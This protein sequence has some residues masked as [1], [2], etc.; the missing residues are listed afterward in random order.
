M[1]YHTVIISGGFLDEEFTL[2]MLQQN[3]VQRI[4]GVDRGIEFL[5]RN[6]IKP[7]LLLGDM[8]SVSPTIIQEYKEHHETP[9]LTY[10][11]VKDASDTE[12]AVRY[13]VEH[14]WS[15][16]VILGA[17]GKRHDHLLANIQILMIALEAGVDACILDPYNRI[18]LFQEGFSLTR[19]ESFGTHFSLFS[20]GGEVRGLTLTG[21]KYPLNN[22][23]IS[24]RDSLCVSNEYS[25]ESDQICITWEEGIMIFM[26][27][28]D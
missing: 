13:A 28:R 22:H 19:E 1:I 11:P 16:L 17:T 25:I 4:I 2:H 15:D 9:I 24:S 5:Y 7:T 6:H 23:T 26:E 10:N 3:E 8:D 12:I 21:A 27:T 14:G 18:R 20:L